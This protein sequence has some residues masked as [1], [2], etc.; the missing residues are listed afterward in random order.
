MSLAKKHA[1]AFELDKELSAEERRYRRV[2]RWTKNVDLFSKDMVIFP[3]CQESDW[4]LMIAV[5]PGFIQVS[6]PGVIHLRF[7]K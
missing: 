1:E 6:N 5:K 3:I 2:E 7:M 4:F